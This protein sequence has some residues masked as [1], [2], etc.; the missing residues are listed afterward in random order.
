MNFISDCLGTD[1]KSSLLRSGESQVIGFQR[2]ETLSTLQGRLDSLSQ[3]QEHTY[4]R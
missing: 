2:V 3:V 1:W 4:D